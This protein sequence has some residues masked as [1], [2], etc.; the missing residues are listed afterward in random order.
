M[1]I[2]DISPYRS[3]SFFVSS[4]DLILCLLIFVFI[5]SKVFPH[6]IRPLFQ[7]ENHSLIITLGIVLYYINRT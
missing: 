2:T 6:S 4:V 3:A 5:C 1:V 7:L